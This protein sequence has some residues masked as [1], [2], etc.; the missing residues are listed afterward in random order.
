M[1]EEEKKST[2]GEKEKSSGQISRRE[3]LRDAGLVVGGATIGSMAILS[4]CGTPATETVTNTLTKTVT[5][6]ASTVTATVGGATVTATAPAVTKTVTVTAPP[7]SVPAAIV[8][9]NMITLNV[10]GADYTLYSDPAWTLQWVLNDR[11]G[12]TGAKDWCDQGACGSCTVNIDGRPVLSCMT[13]AVEAQGKKIETIEGI[14][15]ANHPLIQAWIDNY[16][17]QCGYCTPGAIV[18]AKA[19]LD[20]NKTPTEAQIKE[21]FGGNLCRCA[22]YYKWPKAILAAAAKLGGK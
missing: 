20:N 21:F 4:A 6:A 22:T 10:N 13:L 19:L 3:F 7:S 16:G 17:M 11:M 1:S 9:S 14:A 18:T 5:G 2:P 15:A 8:A 12:L